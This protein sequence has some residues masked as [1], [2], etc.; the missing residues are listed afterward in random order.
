MGSLKSKSG[1][2]AEGI[3]HLK[4]KDKEKKKKKKYCSESDS[5]RQPLEQAALDLDGF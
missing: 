4:R 3:T 2:V 1:A 5:N